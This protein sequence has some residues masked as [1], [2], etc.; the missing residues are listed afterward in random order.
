[1]SDPIEADEVIPPGAPSA[2]VR[3]PG[4]TVAERHATARIIARWLDELLH[5]PGTTFKIGLDPFIALVP[6]IGDFLS[7]SVSAVVILESIRKGVSPSVVGRM[8]VNV[9][10][11][12][13]FDAVP[14]VGPF[15]S[16]FFKSNSRNLELLHRWES[17]EQKAVLKGSRWMLMSVVIVFFICFT[18]LMIGW[19]LYLW[20]LAFGLIKVFKTVIGF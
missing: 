8:G 3:A 13:I 16:A 11:N 2:S 18:A 6:G 9:A 5:I 12:A 7:S 1:M 10:V 15:F 4:K 17:G 19:A 20:S 14:L